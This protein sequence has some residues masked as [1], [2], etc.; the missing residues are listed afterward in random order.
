MQYFE[1]CRVE[2]AFA[3]HAEEG[4]WLTIPEFSPPSWAVSDSTI[5]CED[6]GKFSPPDGLY[7]LPV[8]HE[9]EQLRHS[10]SVIGEIYVA[11]LLAM[12]TY[13]DSLWGWAKEQTL[14][15]LGGTFKPGQLISCD[16][17]SMHLPSREST[18]IRNRRLKLTLR[19]FG[20]NYKCP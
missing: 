1:R 4:A 8:F 14:I 20:T 12:F 17:G 3:E 15:H 13:Y 2:A 10:E 9:D 16:F 18:G 7:P 11:E 5:S 6:L 19:A